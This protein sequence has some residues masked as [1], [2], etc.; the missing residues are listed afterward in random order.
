MEPENSIEQ[1]IQGYIAS[2]DERQLVIVGSTAN[3]FGTQMKEQYGHE[4]GIRFLGAIYDASV[5]NALRYYA[6]LYY[7]GHSVGGTNPSLL[8]AMGC[9][10]RIAAHR[11]PFNGAILG[12][13]AFY[14]SDVAEITGI[15]RSAGPKEEHGAWLDANVQKIR[16]TYNWPAV[17]DAYERVM[18]EACEAR[19]R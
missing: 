1:I 7:H 9:R 11:N 14:F 12:T 6:H 13:E 18:L 3:A 5:I 2:G 17:V 4:K 15:I 8:E 10:A 19:K 16:D